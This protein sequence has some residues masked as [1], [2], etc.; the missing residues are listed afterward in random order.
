MATT[1]PPPPAP[2]EVDDLELLLGLSEDETGSGS[3]ALQ[4]LVEQCVTNLGCVSGAF[5]LPEQGWN[6][7]VKRDTPAN[8]GAAQ[9]L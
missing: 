2:A 6:V 4:K 8:K 5:V 9:F 1:A 7:V 3:G